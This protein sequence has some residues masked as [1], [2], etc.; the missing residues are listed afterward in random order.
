MSKVLVDITRL[1]DRLLQGRLPTGVDRVG[2][3]YV[4][5]FATSARAVVRF[6][7]RSLV[8]SAQDSND[9]FV[10]LLVGR[11]GLRGLVWR[12]VGKELVSWRSHAD[13][14]GQILFNTG[15]T[16]LDNPRYPVQLR[17][18]GVRPVFF[19]HDLIPN[20]HPEYCRAGE[21]DRHAQR[22][23]TALRC[24][25]G[26]ITN[27]RATLDD[28]RYFG[29]ARGYA[30]P[31]AAVA[32]LAAATMPAPE[33]D[34]PLASPYFVMLGTIEARKNHLMI[35]QIWRRL[36]ERMGDAAPRLVIIGQRGWECEN[37][38]DLLER[39]EALQGLVT[40]LNGASDATVSTYLKHAQALLFP[41]FA[42]GY[43]MPLV[44]ALQA[45]TPVIASDLIAFR[46][47]SA[48]IPDYLDSLDALAWMSRIC[49]YA[50]PA[51]KPRAAQQARSRG[52]VAP[53]WAGH[54]AVVDALLERLG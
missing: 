35:L 44:E 52:F 7:G 1:L 43:G 37:V 19:I 17:R 12:L 33:P 46:E 5:H 27:S 29:T 54:F 28:L 53:T 25:K 9:L 36:S 34:R 14:A 4:R 6:G 51:S 39:C 16:G 32:L 3:E 48:D 30:I 23:A 13:I 50:S 42:E 41:S 49:A 20:T 45:G 10:H 38:I 31:P 21:R 24:A 40:E 15:H 2:L 26:L 22:M 8:L 18:M 47:I 11:P